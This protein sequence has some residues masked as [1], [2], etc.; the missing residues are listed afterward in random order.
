MY[1]RGNNKQRIFFL[2][3][4]YEFFLQ[5][6][7]EEWLRYCEILNYCLMPNHFH[8]LIVAN[9]FACE[10]I[11]ISNKLSCLQRFSKGIGKTLSSYTNAI[12][13]Q[14]GTTGSLFQKK[15]KAKCLTDSFPELKHYNTGDY[16]SNCFHYIHMNPIA[17][18]LVKNLKDWPYSSW[19]DYYENRQGSFC[20]KELAMK[21]TGLTEKDFRLN[22]SI[23]PID[24]IVKEIW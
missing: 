17:G 9:A 13:F 14:N 20:N 7:K 12:N 16:I 11:E 15:T 4:N 8:F 5:K 18:G 10:P 3:R 24:E 6:V 19:L 21:L 23:N 2:K 22:S 1:N